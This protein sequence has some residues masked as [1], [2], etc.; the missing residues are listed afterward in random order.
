MRFH[1]LLPGR[2]RSKF[3][4]MTQH[5]F[6]DSRTVSFLCWL[7]I[8]VAAPRCAEAEPST[9]AVSAFNS[10]VRAVESRLAEQHRSPKAFLA[11]STPQNEI[12]LHRGNLVVE[13]LTP[14]GGVA[15][16]GAL[17]HHWRGTAFAPGATSADFERLMRDFKAYPQS[18][19]PEVLQAE[20]LAQRGD[21]FQALIRVRQRHVITVVMD[22]TYDIRFGRLDARHG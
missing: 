9:A 13:Q 11:T 3:K 12:E 20:A 17:L 19:E 7:V 22:T 21:R 2:A 15:L 1:V 16:P 5:G 8:L 6:S 10:Y 14:T 4:G 18:F